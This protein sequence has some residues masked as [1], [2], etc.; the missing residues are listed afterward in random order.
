[1][2]SFI[3][4]GAILLE[5][6][7]VEVDRKVCPIYILIILYDVSR[8]WYY[9]YREM[10]AKLTYIICR[11]VHNMY[12]LYYST[13]VGVLRGWGRAQITV[14]IL[15]RE[16]KKVEKHCT[17]TYTLRRNLP[18]TRL[19]QYILTFIRYVINWFS[20][21]LFLKLNLFLKSHL[22]SGMDP[23]LRY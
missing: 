7:R 17:R 1:M 10:L 18:D 14:D 15:G 16:A 4:K 6:W 20:D 11:W 8:Y 2:V 3:E 23:M 12:V 19:I 22:L 13:D 9:T 5:L 21:H